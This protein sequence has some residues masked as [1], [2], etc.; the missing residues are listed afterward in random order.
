M[1]VKHFGCDR[2]C[3]V[4]LQQRELIREAVAEPADDLN[5]RGGDGV[6]EIN[7]DDVGLQI[8][9]GRAFGNPVVQDVDWSSEQV[10]AQIPMDR[11]VFAERGLHDR[12]I[13]WL[14][15]ERCR[16]RSQS[17]RR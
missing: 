16:G 9:G 5:P 17:M 7:V 6:S 11:G 14:E 8:L 10:A 15:F 3:A 12:R 1:G 2:P 4:F 13:D